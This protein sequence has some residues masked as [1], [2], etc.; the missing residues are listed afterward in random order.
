MTSKRYI[1]DLEKKEE[2]DQKIETSRKRKILNDELLTVKK[3]KLDEEFL[4]KKL[5]DDADKFIE[6]AARDGGDEIAGCKGAV[7]Q[8]IRQRERKSIR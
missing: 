6:Q 5:K 7:L 3:K 4:M 2:S 8:T 1:E